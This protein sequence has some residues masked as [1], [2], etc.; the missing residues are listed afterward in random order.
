MYTEVRTE[1]PKVEANRSRGSWV[2]IGQTDNKNCAPLLSTINRWDLCFHLISFITEFILRSI[3]LEIECRNIFKIFLQLHVGADDLHEPHKISSDPHDLLN[4][5]RD[6][7]K[8]SALHSFCSCWFF[9]YY[10]GLFNLKSN[11][12]LQR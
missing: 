8:K 5:V 4:D 6:T 2:M 9:F 3:C 1:F 7:R 10:C 12:I 11:F